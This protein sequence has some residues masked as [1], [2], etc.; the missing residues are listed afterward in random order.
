MRP[1]KNYELSHEVSLVY[2]VLVAQIHYRKDT[3]LA[4]RRIKKGN[5]FRFIDGKGKSASK[6]AISRILKLAIPPAWKD[7]AISADPMD[8]ILAV[9]VDA[10]GRKQ[11]IYHPE[12]MRRNQEHKFD[13]MIMFGERLPALREVVRAHMREHSL[14][15][16]RVIATVVWLLEH[17]F[18]RVGNEEYAEEH[19]SYGLTTMHKKH[20]EIEGN[21]MTFSFEGKSG[22]FHELGI[23]H[24]RVAKTIKA[25]ID[26]PGYK[27]FQYVDEQ[28]NRQVVDSAH[29]NQYLQTHTGADFSAKDFRTWGGSVLAGNSLYRKGTPQS[30]A[31]LKANIADVVAK[32][33]AHLGNTTRI[34]RTYY[35]HPAII[36][37]YERNALVPHFERSYSQKSSKEP[38]LAPAEYATWSLIKNA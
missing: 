31:D 32:V 24:P 12:W 16:N 19:H 7:V 15:Q 23:N 17:T 35:I 1:G 30:E 13:Q 34:C 33:A 3:E 8:Y 37:S 20:I 21:A 11:Y 4:L 14:T 26:L 10:A 2:N 28:N 27:L 18:I 6:N 25:C 36:K 22:V 9:G 38:T 5:G 29:V